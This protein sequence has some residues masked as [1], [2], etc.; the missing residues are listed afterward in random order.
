MDGNVK[1]VENQC[2][3]SGC[4]HVKCKYVVTIVWNNYAIIKFHFYHN[5][6]SLFN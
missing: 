3:N 1:C 4:L 5:V 2:R 6:P